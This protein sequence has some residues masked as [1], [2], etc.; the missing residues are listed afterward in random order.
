MTEHGK[1]SEEGEIDRSS[2]TQSYT[3]WYNLEICTPPKD[4]N[5]TVQESRSDG[6]GKVR[7]STGRVPMVAV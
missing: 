3:K 5:K 7:I 6:E 1:G 2:R 4:K